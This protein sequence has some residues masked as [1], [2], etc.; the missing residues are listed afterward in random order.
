MSLPWAGFAPLRGN[1][2]HVFC[3]GCGRRFANMERQKQDPPSAELVQCWCERCSAGCK[4]T[5]EYYYDRDGLRVW[6]CEECGCSVG[7]PGLCGECAEGR[8]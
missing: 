7:S 4:D 6:A 2:I 8:G 3:P 1:R 5:P